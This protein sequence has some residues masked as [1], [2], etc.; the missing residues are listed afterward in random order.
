VVWFHEAR[1]AEHQDFDSL[2]VGDPVTFV[3]EEIAGERGVKIAA[4]VMCV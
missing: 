3:L 1:M 4:N 2:R